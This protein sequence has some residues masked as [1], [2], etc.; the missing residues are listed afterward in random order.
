MRAW[1]LVMLV[2]LFAAGDIA[3]AEDDIPLADDPIFETSDTSES[4][5]LD[6]FDSYE[7]SLEEMA[8][9]FSLSCYEKLGPP[10]ECFED[11][12]TPECNTTRISCRNAG[13][14]SR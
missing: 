14:Y 7:G 4:H 9:K 6:E 8:E 1:I 5:P 10:S 3:R 11:Y 2:A 12:E 13:H